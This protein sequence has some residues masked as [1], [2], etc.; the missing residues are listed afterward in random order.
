PAC[1]S[2]WHGRPACASPW[3]GRPACASPWHGRP[4][5]ASETVKIPQTKL[6]MIKPIVKNYCKPL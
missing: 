4:A 2:P 5:C 3:H 1:A 6:A